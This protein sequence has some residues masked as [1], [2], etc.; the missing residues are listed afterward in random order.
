MS[1]LFLVA[2]IVLGQDAQQVKGGDVISKML[3]YYHDAKTI[4]GTIT[5]SQHSGSREA[6]V[7]TELQFQ[8]PASLYIRQSLRASYGTDQYL[9][10]SDGKTF[11]YDLP[12][13]VP[14]KDRGIQ[15]G[16]RVVET[17]NPGRPLGVRDIFTAT[18]SW[19]ID[20][21]TPLDLIIG[22]ADDLRFRN[23]QWVTADIVGR[24]NLGSTAVTVV[25]GQWRDYPQYTTKQGRKIPVPPSATYQMFIDDEHRLLRY[26]EK[27]NVGATINNQQVVQSVETIWDVNVV[28]DGPVKPELFKVVR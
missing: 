27:T 11:S 13:G 12:D 15:G 7:L 6:S 18:S 16:L 28:K 9:V 1:A 8:G 21:S 20:R 19:L 10:T 3:A 14:Y 25:G 4:A 24:T 23:A 2:S 26:T 17:C 22:A 5:M